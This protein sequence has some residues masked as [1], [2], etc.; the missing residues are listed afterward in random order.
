MVPT[1]G[2]LVAIGACARGWLLF[3]T[4]WVP[5]INGAY[6]LVQARAILERG[7]L[8]IP[9]MPL[10]LRHTLSLAIML[11]VIGTSTLTVVRGGHPIL[12]DDALRELGSL[13][14]LIADPE[15]TLISAQHGAEWW[16]AWLLRT[17]IAQAGALR[18]EDWTTFDRVLF[19]QV[20]SGMQMP[21]FGKMRSSGTR[22]P[23]IPETLR[24]K[25]SG[26]FAAPIPADAQVLHD[27]EH[28][29][30]AR[31]VRPPLSV[32]EAARP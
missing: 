5:G 28:L 24:G 31:V 8:G 15:R 26:L 16:T 11:L 20:K 18:P 7:T 25:P 17:R 29:T 22:P 12:S 4:P 6:Y 9:D 32:S 3:S 1:G 2:A 23:T 30:L 27:G 14:P 10:L 19:L 13:R 21:G